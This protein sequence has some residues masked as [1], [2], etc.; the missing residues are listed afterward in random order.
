M[1]NIYIPAQ[2]PE[3]WKQLLADPEKQWKEGYSAH[4]LAHCWQNADGLPEEVHAVLTGSGIPTLESPELL[5]GLP[6]HRVPLPGGTTPSQT[7]LWVLARVGSELI[8]IAVEG[9]VSESFGPTLGRWLQDASSGK[10]KRLKYLAQ[11]LGL[12]LP[13][14][15]TIRYQL[16]HRTA[17]AIIEAERFNAAGAMLLVHSFSQS[18]DWFEDYARFVALFGAEAAP[19]T[20][21]EGKETE[22]IRLYFAWV[23]GS[24]N[25]L[26]V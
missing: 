1:S 7:D 19:N 15:D 12:S 23:R 2:E 21:V 9:K 22:P 4:A 16:I 6:E 3:D 11:K 8:S 13:L 18:D 25:Y 5:I 20:A 17:S 24:E 26:H 10:Q 14:P